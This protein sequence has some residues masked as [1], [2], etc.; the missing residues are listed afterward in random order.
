MKQIK[1]DFNNYTDISHFKAKTPYP[2]GN[3][4]ITRKELI[5]ILYKYGGFSNISVS[6]KSEKLY[7]SLV[8]FIFDVHE[9]GD[10]TISFFRND[11]YKFSESSFIGKLS[12][13]HGMMGAIIF[14]D[15]FL[16]VTEML[17]LTDKRLDVYGT[18]SPDFF[19][20]N[21]RGDAILLEA[22]GSSNIVPMKTIN[23]G[24]KQVEGITRVERSDKTQTFVRFKKYVSTSNFDVNNKYYIDLIDPVGKGDDYIKFDFDHAIYLHY[25]YIF[26]YL[27]KNKTS[28]TTLGK[29]VYITSLVGE[30]RIGI[31]KVVYE[32]LKNY[33]KGNNNS[34]YD[35][36]R[37]ITEELYGEEE[38]YREPEI[39]NSQDSNAKKTVEE[40]KK[41]VESREYDKSEMH[42]NLEKQEEQEVH[43]DY[44][45]VNGYSIGRDGICI[46]SNPL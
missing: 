43:Y 23:Y 11:D 39:S 20:L 27:E 30:D 5:S 22:K 35:E 16:N 9:N 7:Y 6:K 37:E 42:D 12:F 10:N 40:Y 32:L 34:L 2:T 25:S 31:I 4:R 46:R 17:H 33:N 21:K 18:K 36:I 13:I 19:A 38:Y 8:D 26:N 1:I 28:E 15:K 3:F 14:A 45:N 24:I 29:K 41:N 44:L